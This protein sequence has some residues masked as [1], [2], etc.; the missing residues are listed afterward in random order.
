MKQNKIIWI[1]LVLTLVGLILYFATLNNTSAKGGKAYGGVLRISSKS[2]KPT[3]FPLANNTIE[4]Q[5]LQQL[6]FEP[7]LKPAQNERGWRYCLAS[8][9][10]LNSKRNQVLIHLKKNIHFT[11]NPCF[12]FHTSELSAE[13]VAFSLS[14]ACTKQE[15]I[16]QE[17]LLP[18]LIV[19]GERFYHNKSNPIQTYVSGIRV[20]D[21]YTLQIKLTSAYNHFF[22][23]LTSPSLGIL[24]KQAAKYYGPNIAS[25]P[26]GTGP[27]LLQNK[28]KNT[29]IFERNPSY[30]RHDKYGNQLPYLDRVELSCGASGQLAQKL[31]LKN[32]LDLLFD[33]PLDDLREAF[34]T[35]NDAKQGKN[36]LH[37]VYIKNAA[38]VHF[39]QFSCKGSFQ[40]LAVR[41]AFALV[42]DSETICEEV[43]KGE[44]KSII[45]TTC[46]FQTLETS[47]KK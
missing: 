12:R 11:D 35:L 40:N 27:F 41:K 1:S 47:L 19:G 28:L 39:I 18:K 37:E 29:Y 44:P 14:L 34:G 30:W 4:A 24:S 3:I 16:Q 20:I 8:Q 36:P 5:R 23:L 17:L 15:K 45:K 6:I 9:I 46:S 42:I 7:L 33:L 25:H 10:E 31:L 21:N 38:K 43:L 13:D 26:V 32:K 22:N 2:K